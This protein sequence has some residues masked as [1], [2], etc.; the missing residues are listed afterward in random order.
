MFITGFPLHS[1]AKNDMPR[2]LEIKF[3]DV[4]YGGAGL[5]VFGRDR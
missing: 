5:V 3:E 2:I 4:P 1:S